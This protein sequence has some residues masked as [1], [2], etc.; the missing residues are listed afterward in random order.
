[1][2]AGSSRYHFLIEMKCYK[3]KV[4]N[5][6]YA[7][8]PTPFMEEASFECPKGYTALTLTPSLSSDVCIKFIDKEQPEELYLGAVFAASHFLFK[9]RGLPLSSLEIATPVRNYIV[10]R[11]NGFYTFGHNLCKYKFTKN[12]ETLRGCLIKYTELENFDLKIYE[13][14]NL[15]NFDVSA[16][17][18]PLLE[19]A[20]FAIVFSFS[21]GEI[22]SRLVL[23]D[24]KSVTTPSFA[25]SVLLSLL[26]QNGRLPYGKSVKISVD[27]DFIFASVSGREAIISVPSEKI[28]TPQ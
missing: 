8:I 19:S 27:G 2:I 21:E 16:I 18:L 22:K 1:M 13:T 4:L 12:A 15:D 6:N 10:N 25:F 20:A 23:K 11:K 9:I 26:S 3:I 24:E 17:T 7:V 14:E 28:Y 5:Q